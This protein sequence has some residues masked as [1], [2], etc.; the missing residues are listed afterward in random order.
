MLWDKFTGPY[1]GVVWTMLFC[2]TIVPFAMAWKKVR[3][4]M[5]AMFVISLLLQLGMWLERFQIVSPPLASNHEPWT[6]VV[7]W[8]GL[9]QM[10]ITAASFGWFT[11]L[12]LIFCKVFPSVSMYEVKEMVYHRN[13]H[14]KQKLQDMEKIKDDMIKTEEGLS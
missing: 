6:Q 13:K 3:V 1:A 10:T 14:G 9:V 11:M 8:P 4:N 12:F 2:A 7:V 5:W